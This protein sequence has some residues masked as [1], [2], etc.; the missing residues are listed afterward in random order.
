M[1]SK[2]EPQNLERELRKPFLLLSRTHFYLFLFGCFSLPVVVLAFYTAN[3]HGVFFVAFV[4]LL[5][6]GFGEWYLLRMWEIKMQS[7]VSKIIKMRLNRTQLS[8]IS[9][10]N[11]LLK[12]ELAE[13]RRGYEH[14]IDLLQ[15]S[16]AKSKEE[17]HQLNLEMDRKLEEMRVA[18]LEFEDLRKDYHRLEE[19]TAYGL[20]EKKKEIEHQ[21]SLN[22]EYQRT[23]SEQRMIIEKKQRYIGKLEEKIRDL[24][25]EIR[26]LL[27]LE[28]TTKDSPPLDA[29]ISLPSPSS[30]NPYDL[31][32]HLQYYIQKTEEEMGMSHLGGKSSRFLDSSDSYVID[33]RRLFD[34][35]RDETVGIIFVLSLTEK[36]FLF[37][38]KH[39]KTVLGWNPEKFM[40][41]F[42]HLVISGYRDWKRVVENIT[43]M[44]ESQ[45]RIVIAEKSGKSKELTSVMGIVKKGPFRNHIIGIF[46]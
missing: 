8:S 12:I 27:Q 9:E 22:S 36:K 17:V 26:S 33:R 6:F 24:M 30:I 10:E 29:K 15:S 46:S 19:D 39:V 45:T 31:S 35:F 41:D 38:N 1:E 42:S 14:Q 32:L 5:I 23:I 25:Y 18:Y 34:S 7:S 21:K 11:H 13:G 44:D 2:F 28:E 3:V 43:T 37:V 16:V 20:Q 40:K 4:S